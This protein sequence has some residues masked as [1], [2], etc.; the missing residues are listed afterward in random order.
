MK[1]KNATLL[2]CALI[3]LM[4][5]MNSC[6]YRLCYFFRNFTNSPIEITIHMNTND[7]LDSSKVFYTNHLL[8]IN[9]HTESCLVDS[10]YLVKKSKNT[11]QLTIPA[12]STCNFYTGIFQGHWDSGIEEIILSQNGRADT[13]NANN[14]GSFSKRY[15]RLG[16]NSIHF[17]GIPHNIVCFDYG[18]EPK[19]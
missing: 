16:N 10:T 14:C 11:L 13:L 8:K 1:Y 12:M 5:I 2:L 7:L 18:D 17:Y 4:F 9:S 19:H 15:N 6:V 3:A